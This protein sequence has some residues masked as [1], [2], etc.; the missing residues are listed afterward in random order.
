MGAV[1][2][3]IF[4]VLTFL[5][6]L[7]SVQLFAHLD[8]FIIRAHARQPEG[9]SLLYKGKISLPSAGSSR[10]AAAAAASGLLL[11][12]LP[13]LPPCPPPPPRDSPPPPAPTVCV[14]EAPG[15]RG[16]HFPFIPLLKL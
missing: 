16:S 11:D 1:I 8:V 12:V 6:W 3:G 9:A 15:F 10:S 2:P 14:R 7:V 4:E 5:G 13:H